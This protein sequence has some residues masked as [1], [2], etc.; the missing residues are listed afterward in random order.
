M[1]YC[2]QQNNVVPLLQCFKNPLGSV[3]QIVLF[4]E[5]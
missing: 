5:A 1:V 4:V 3:K 2:A